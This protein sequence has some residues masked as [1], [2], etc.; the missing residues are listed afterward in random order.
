MNQYYWQKEGL[1]WI[2]IDGKNLKNTLSDYENNHQN[3]L[4]TV[5]WFSQDTKL[6]IKA[7]SFESKQESEI[8]K[9]QDMI[10]DCGLQNKVLT[11]DALHCN[12]NKDN[13]R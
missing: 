13:N 6:V 12:N 10:R 8:A 11:L 2:A 5:S 4:I 7:E 3:V 1:D 9:V